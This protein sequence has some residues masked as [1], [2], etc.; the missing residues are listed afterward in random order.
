M[1]DS[2]LVQDF[3]HLRTHCIKLKHSFVTYNRL[4]NE[5]NR[6]LLGAVAPTFFSDIAEIMHRDWVLQ[7]CKLMDPS[8]TK[9]KGMIL[10]NI[11]IKLINKQL[12][13]SGL[14]STTISSLADSLL[15]YGEKIKPARDKR[16]AHFDRDHQLSE[17]LLGS[18]SELELAEFI[19]NLQEYCDQVGIALGIGPLDFGSGGCKGDVLDLLK[20]LKQARGA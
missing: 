7:A 12:D 3:K 20:C 11:T 18:T 5:S 8:D 2:K 1:S 19:T 14:L 15:V 16:I 10:E 17:N 4:F 9:R 6:D 13:S